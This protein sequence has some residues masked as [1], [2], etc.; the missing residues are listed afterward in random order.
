[1]KEENID[2]LYTERL[3]VGVNH[4]NELYFSIIS[5]QNKANRVYVS[6]IAG[7]GCKVGKTENTTV[8]PTM[9]TKPWLPE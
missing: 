8:G 2:Y 5:F 4:K 1:M 3:F 7:V 6:D 9:V